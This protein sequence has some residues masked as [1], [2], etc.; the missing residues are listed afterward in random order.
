MIALFLLQVALAD[1]ICRD[2]WRSSSSGSGTCSHHGGVA[3]WIPSAPASS[4]TT[5]GVYV[6][7]PH[8]PSYNFGPFQDL[9]LDIYSGK[10]PDLYL[11]CLTCDPNHDDP[12]IWL[13][14]VRRRGGKY[15]VN[16]GKSSLW[17][18]WTEGH[19]SA[20]DDY[21]ACN[22]KA[23]NP[24]KVF[25]RETHEYVGRL[26]LNFNLPDSIKVLEVVG[27]VNKFC[28]EVV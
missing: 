11:G 22:A 25:N 28:K 18:S 4:Y 24:P 26:T 10:D 21:S 13:K 3:Y 5:N 19:V 14:S 16:G 1:A 9:V 2:G 6:Y 7:K 27:F 15:H 8:Y 17:G 23:T 20:Y 12:E